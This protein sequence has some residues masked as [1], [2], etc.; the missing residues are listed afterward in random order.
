MTRQ[1]LKTFKPASL[2]G[3]IFSQLKEL[4]LWIIST[5]H[6]MNEI[7]YLPGRVLMLQQGP[8][9][10]EVTVDDLLV[11]FDADNLETLFLRMPGD[12]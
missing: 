9:N 6:Y 7:E 11:K 12:L 1:L 10:D 3:M 5:C 8:I 2:F 4:G